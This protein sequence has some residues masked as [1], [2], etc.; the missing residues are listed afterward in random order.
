[1]KV[2][3]PLAGLG[4]RLRPHTH[5]RPKPLINVA[6]KPVLGHILDKLISLDISE[7]IFITGYLGE[8]IEEYV[9]ANYSFPAQFLEQKERLGQAHAIHLAKDLVNEPV[10][11]IFVDTIFEADLQQLVDL[12]SDGVIYV[13]EVTDPRRFGVVLLKNGFV[14]KLLEKPKEPISNLAVIGV[15]YLKNAPLLFSCIEELF[16]RQIKTQ[17]EYFLADALQLMIDQGAKL[18]AA[19]VEVWEDCGKPE[20]LLQTNRYLLRN[21]GGQNV[22]VFDSIVIPPVYIARSATIINSIIGPYVTIADHSV[23]KN[24][25][26][27]DSIINDGSVIEDSM[28]SGSLIGSEARVRGTYKR[29]NVGDSSEVDME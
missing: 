25:I 17:G 11:I 4:T 22:D 29:L 26:I 28:L 14:G 8:Q 13:K 2:I 6:G 20:S 15:Y 16:T 7:I 12:A 18:E 3:I 9:K 10:L 21:G 1:M 5:T 23:I 24:S 27:K 19:K